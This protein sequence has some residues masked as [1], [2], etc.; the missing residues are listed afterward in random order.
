[1]LARKSSIIPTNSIAPPPS[2]LLL[3]IL[4][5]WTIHAREKRKCPC[6]DTSSIP[7]ASQPSSRLCVLHISSHVLLATL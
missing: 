6:Y 5:M 1:M 4:R 7:N 2:F 3:Y